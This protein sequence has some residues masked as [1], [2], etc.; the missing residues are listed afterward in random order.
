MEDYI[1]YDYI[2]LFV[3]GS[4][5]KSLQN[6]KMTFWLKWNWL[7]FVIDKGNFQ[8]LCLWN[9][10]HGH[11]NGQTRGELTFPFISHV[12]QEQ[13]LKKHM[14]LTLGRLGL[15]RFTWYLQGWYSVG[16]IWLHLQG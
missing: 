1:I 3:W 10:L 8:E 6:P 13:T 9:S 14:T 16:G 11:T 5:I 7:Y 15:V 12:N 4:M 2:E